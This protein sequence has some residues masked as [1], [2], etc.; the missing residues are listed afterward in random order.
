MLCSFMWGALFVK[1]DLFQRIKKVVN[2][3]V[4]GNNVL[5]SIIL[6][7]AFLVRAMIP[8]HAASVFLW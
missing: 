2:L 8:I 7:S 1:Y 6:V 4:Y 3:N 5:M